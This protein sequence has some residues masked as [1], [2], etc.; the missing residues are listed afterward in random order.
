[1]APLFAALFAPIAKPRGIPTLLWW[2]AH[3]SVTP[4]LRLAHAMV[5]GCVTPTRGS[6]PLPSSKLAIVGHGI[7]TSIVARLRHIV[8]EEHSL[9]RLAS[10]S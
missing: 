9:D 2:F 3:T 6:F 7:D 8:T 5:D 4:T 1:M 10:A